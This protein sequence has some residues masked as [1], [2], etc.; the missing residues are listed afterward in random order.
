MLDDPLER[1]SYGDFD[2]IEPAKQGKTSGVS[3]NGNGKVLEKLVAGGCYLILWDLENLF[4][5]WV[6]EWGSIQ[7]AG[8]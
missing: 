7:F 5:N 3:G 1:V 2:P 4:R 8:I 6:A